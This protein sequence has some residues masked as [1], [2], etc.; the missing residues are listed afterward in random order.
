MKKKWY[1]LIGIACFVIF[2]FS[3][4]VMA[5]KEMKNSLN[6]SKYYKAV[7]GRNGEIL[8]YDSLKNELTTI[9][10]KGKYDPKV[11]KDRTTILYR[12]SV[13]E[14]TNKLVFGIMNMEGRII[15]EIEID[16]EISNEILNIDWISKDLV[17]IETHINPSSSEFFVYDINTKNIVKHFVGSSFRVIPQTEKI[18]YQENV[19]HW[20]D[21]KIFHSLFIDENKVYTSE[22]K[23]TKIGPPVF[24]DD[25][26]RVA[27]IEF[28]QEEGNDADQ[29]HCHLI[30]CDFNI[31]ECKIIKRK[32]IE[33]D[34]DMLEKIEFDKKDNVLLRYNNVDYLYDDRM[35]SFVV[36]DFHK[37]VEEDDFLKY[38][39]VLQKKLMEIYGDVDMHMVYSINWITEEKY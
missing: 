6:S 19:P 34:V 22:L 2:I 8:I 16:T 39:K 17:G 29:G 11:S 3:S 14:T 21:D 38:E 23:D 9:S 33:I 26:E 25:L 27:F 10:E 36:C 4:V 1:L 12:R 20:S 5:S 37:G 15:N 18:I 31:N 35:E 13:L 30:V 24:S 7:F 32:S 28:F